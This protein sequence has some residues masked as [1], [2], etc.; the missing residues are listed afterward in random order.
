MTPNY[1]AAEY[2]RAGQRN[3]ITS[4]IY[5]EK[6]MSQ[7]YQLGSRGY[8]SSHR[9]PNITI[10]MK[11]IFK[12]SFFFGMINHSECI[13]VDRSVKFVK[14]F[15]SFTMKKYQQRARGEGA[16]SPPAPNGFIMR[17]WIINQKLYNGY[18]IFKISVG[19]IQIYI[20]YSR[21]NRA[22]STLLKR[23]FLQ[24][25]FMWKTTQKRFPNVSSSNFQFTRSKEKKKKNTVPIFG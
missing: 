10:S 24:E 8:T 15:P 17:S 21:F 25:G 5:P 18:Y 22:V 9:E 19:L 3:C 7:G 20:K 1:R 14:F 2:A 6:L 13:C 4:S 11:S 23:Y 12:R 16:T